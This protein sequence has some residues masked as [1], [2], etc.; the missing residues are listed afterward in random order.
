MHKRQCIIHTVHSASGLSVR[1]KSSMLSRGLGREMIYGNRS[2]D[3]KM[4][5]GRVTEL[6]MSASEQRFH[7]S[8][9]IGFLR[10]DLIKNFFSTKLWFTITYLILLLTNSLLKR[11]K[12]KQKLVVSHWCSCMNCIHTLSFGWEWQKQKLFLN[13]FTSKKI[14]QKKKIFF[15]G[16]EGFSTISKDQQENTWATCSKATL[17]E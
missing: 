2:C 16:R 17:Q 11:K 3:R 6:S 15:C 9:N 12:Q 10:Q 5:R 13:P 1:R 14:H 8:Y 7:F 4:R